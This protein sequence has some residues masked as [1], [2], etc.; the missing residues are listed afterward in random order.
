MEAKIHVEF[1]DNNTYY[2]VYLIRYAN[3]DVKIVNCA[4]FFDSR[5][6]AKFD[7]TEIFVKSYYVSVL[8]QNRGEW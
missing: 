1:R 2:L 4:Y 3:M 6:K 7:K 8:I 5:I